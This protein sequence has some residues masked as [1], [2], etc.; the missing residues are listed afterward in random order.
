[1]SMRTPDPLSDM[2]TR[3]RNAG[4]AGHKVVPVISTSLTRSVASA[5]LRNG[6]IEAFTGTFRRPSKNSPIKFDR[7]MLISIKYKG[8]PNYRLLKGEPFIKDIQRISKPGARRY[9]R[10]YRPR[11]S[12]LAS[13]SMPG[14]A[15]ST[16][17]LSTSK[18]ILSEKE[19]CKIK[20]G[21]EILGFI[22]S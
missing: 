15:A 18:G 14:N 4:A 8:A 5:L 9:T 12:N 7:F 11:T 10:A 17:L 19:A 1:M 16:T 20:V 6:F 2:F 3:I 21:G 22:K 13:M